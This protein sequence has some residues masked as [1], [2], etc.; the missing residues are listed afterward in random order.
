MVNISV[1]YFIYSN[2]NIELGN[3]RVLIIGDSHPTRSINPKYLANAVNISQTAEPYILT[4]WKLRKVLKTNKPEIVVIGFAPHNISQFNDYKFSDKFW[5]LEMFKRSYP[6]HNFNEVEKVIEVDY[7]QFLEVYFKNNS[8]YPKLD[9]S[10]YI[11]EY[12]NSD[13]RNISG[14]KTS[15]KRH[16]YKDDKEVGV[17]MVSI[18]YLESIIELCHRNDIKVFLVSSPV[19]V[20]YY[21]AIPD[22]ILKA[23]D[24]LKRKYS[25]KAIIFDKTND[26]SYPDSLFRNSDHVNNLGATKFTSEL[27]KFIEG[28]E[29]R[30]LN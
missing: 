20:D 14:W 9:H 7:H 30:D 19:H 21:S 8:F 25:S 16:Y 3:P 29:R 28:K 27:K 1:N 17:S 24:S 12:S 26:F 4:Y 23:Y 6:I 10:Y 22:N 2:Q 13:L 15:I 11:G 18:N 5:S